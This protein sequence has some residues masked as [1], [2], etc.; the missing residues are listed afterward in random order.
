MFGGVV[1]V[2][3]GLI[4][5]M[6]NTD[7]TP[8]G[9]ILDALKVNLRDEAGNAFG[10]IANPIV[11]QEPDTVI[12]LQSN[13]YDQVTV[14]NAVPTTIVSYTVP[15]GKIAYVERIAVSG[16]NRALFEVFQD[17]V[18]VDSSRTFVGGSLNTMFDFISRNSFGLPLVAGETI[19]VRATTSGGGAGL[20][21]GRIQ[22]LEFDA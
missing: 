21:D 11:V 18:Q 15:V 9:N 17:L 10:T 16:E 19:S 22:Y 14:P 8:I 1:R 7:G 3:G 13:V 4:K 20:F 5:L 2:I 6:G 12:I